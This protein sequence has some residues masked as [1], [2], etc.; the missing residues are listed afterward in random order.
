MTAS[1]RSGLLALC[2]LLCLAWGVAG[3]Q[4][5]QPIPKFESLVTDLT[6]TLTAAE[7]NQIDQTLT[8]YQQRKGSQI[9]VLLVKTTEPEEI[10]QYS[11]RVAEAWK[12]GRGTVNNQKVDDGVLLLL[13]VDDHHVRI[14]VGY[15]LEGSLTDVMSRRI[16]DDTMR[17][18][19]R[20]GQYAAAIN[21]G[22]AQIIH[23]IDG[24]ALP[25]ADTHWQGSPQLHSL[26]PVLFI[27]FFVISSVLRALLGRVAGAG[28]TA[29]IMGLIV[30]LVSSLLWAAGGVAVV[31]FLAALIFGFSGSGW[32][33]GGGLGGFGGF[34]GGFG[35]GMGGGGGFSGGGG[36]SFGGG[37]ASGSW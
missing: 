5:L 8:A 3:A 34:G 4:A 33:S 12:V 24:E 16:I 6:G 13:A 36:G 15:G 19:L 10:E 21:A 31:A 17:P 32:R 26:L 7:Q 20:Q 18:L 23:V 9:A 35:G 1:L 14:E 28:A 2:S 30:W 25:P 22:V 11:I 37:G 27:A 29:G